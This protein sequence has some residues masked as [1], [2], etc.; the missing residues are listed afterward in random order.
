MMGR[1]FLKKIYDITKRKPKFR[2]FSFCE[3]PFKTRNFHFFSFSN[4]KDSFATT[5]TTSKE[6]NNKDESSKNV[7]KPA[8]QNAVPSIFTPKLPKTLPKSKTMPRLTSVTSPKKRPK[9][10]VSKAQVKR[11]KFDSPNQSRITDFFKK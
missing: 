9:K 2:L 6:T 10:S 11:L 3:A 4:D 5:A 8:K 7:E 1:Y